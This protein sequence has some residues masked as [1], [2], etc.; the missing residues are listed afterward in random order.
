MVA[1][2]VLKNY[3]TPEHNF[4]YHKKLHVDKNVD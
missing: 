1:G 2:T 4:D 3:P